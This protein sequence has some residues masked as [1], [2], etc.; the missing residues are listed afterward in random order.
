MKKGDSKERREG[1]RK[2]NRIKC[3]VINKL[4]QFYVFRNLS[5][6]DATR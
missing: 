1:G 2:G 6:S 3:C 4:I 5:A